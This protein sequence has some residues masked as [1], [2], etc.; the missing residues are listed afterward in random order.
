MT[1]KKKF[2]FLSTFCAPHILRVITI[3]S[4]RSLHYPL[5][6]YHKTEIKRHIIVL[7]QY[8]II[9]LLNIHFNVEFIHS[10]NSII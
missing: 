1:Y 5:N 4:Q 10:T 6:Y 7:T 9:I 8:K 3:P 2:T